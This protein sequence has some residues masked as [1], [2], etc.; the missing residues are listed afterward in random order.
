[1]PV[2]FDL[3][4]H[5][6]PENKGKPG[7]NGHVPTAENASKIR[8]MLMAGMRLQDIARQLGL[9]SPTLRK[10]YF[11]NGKVNYRHARDMALAEAK[12]KNLLQL[13][14]AADDGNVSAMKE[15][16]KVVT[17]EILNHMDDGATKP[18]KDTSLRALPAGKKAMT[19]LH[20]DEGE[21]ELAQL[22]GEERMH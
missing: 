14:A 15:V 22:F 1:M 20:A 9:S 4:G 11:Q 3:L 13:Q 10:H 6:I 12:A 7:A 17:A 2:E 8:T 16:R 18:K 19:K 5:P 21:D